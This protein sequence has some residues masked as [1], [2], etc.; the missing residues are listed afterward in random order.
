MHHNSKALLCVSLAVD[1]WLYS[2]RATG[3][4]STAEG[5]AESCFSHEQTGSKHALTGSTAKKSSELLMKSNI[6]T[7]KAQQL[8][9]P[10]YNLDVYTYIIFYNC[11]HIPNSRSTTEML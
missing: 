8:T 2:C 4:V 5:R 10:A 7:A 9:C 1:D 3:W 6:P 11:V